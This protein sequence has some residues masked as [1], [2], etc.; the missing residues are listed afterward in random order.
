M[1]HSTGSYL[2]LGEIELQKGD[3]E[4]A[5]GFPR[6]CDPRSIRKT[7]MHTMRSVA[8][9]RK[10]GRTALRPTANLQLQRTLRTEKHTAEEDTM[11]QIAH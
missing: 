3:P 4:L 9:I 1:S 2:M 7:T 8:P 10:L 5:R 11:E 6:A